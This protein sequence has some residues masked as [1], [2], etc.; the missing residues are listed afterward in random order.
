MSDF[1]VFISV[2]VWVVIDVL[3]QVNTPKLVVNNVFNEGLFTQPNRT[4]LFIDPLG[5]T[6]SMLHPRC[7]SCLMCLSLAPLGNGLPSWAPPAAIIPAILA[8]IL[9]FVDQHITALIVNRKD[10]KLKVGFPCG[11][12]KIQYCH[13]SLSLVHHYRKDQATILIY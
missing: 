5:K 11:L 3:A 9:L 13:L 10:N 6:V 8:T 2:V 4:S 1:A 7:L 12:S